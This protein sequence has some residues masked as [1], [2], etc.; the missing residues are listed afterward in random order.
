[1]S[2]RAAMRAAVQ[3]PAV[4]VSVV[5]ATALGAVASLQG[6]HGAEVP[7]DQVVAPERF[8]EAG[9]ALAA[10]AG[11][12]VAAGARQHGTMRTWWCAGVDRPGLVASVLPP[13]LVATTVVVLAWWLASGAVVV[14]V[15][16]PPSRLDDPRVV[17][18]V[19]WALLAALLSGA[20]GALI[21]IGVGRTWRA[22]LIVAFA[23]LAFTSDA[24][25]AIG[26]PPAAMVALSPL[27]AVRG[28]A[29]GGTGS[30]LAGFDVDRGQT[31]VLGV[32]TVAWFLV[33]GAWAMRCSLLVPV[34]APVPASARAAGV[35]GA[36]VVLGYL[37][38]VAARP[39]V[40]WQ[41]RP[42]WRAAEARGRS[43]VQVADRWLRC[44]QSP[45]RDRCRRWERP[46]GMAP[47]PP[48][49]EQIEVATGF[50]LPQPF[51]LTAPTEVVV[52][53]RIPPY[54]SGRT[55]VDRAGVRLRFTTDGRGGYLLAGVDGPIAG[56]AG[57]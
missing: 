26:D 17:E 55:I 32:A 31:V 8:I 41:L 45:G 11:A 12:L 21:G 37:G 53:L 6:H 40:P 46:G 49:L 51:S 9:L 3:D 56:T 43:S 14:V 4:R 15:Q 25:G 38:P 18:V 52:V 47:N 10:V 13:A 36:L 48:A 34:R 23:S 54:R 50:D 57:S 28:F 5:V 42:P 16:G 1:M 33:L 30:V 7:I 44:R 2:V 19:A 27:G 20:A 22:A 29:S 35:L 24:L 39:T